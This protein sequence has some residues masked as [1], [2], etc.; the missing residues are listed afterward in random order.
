MMQSYIY[1]YVYMCIYIYIYIYMYI[2]GTR[3]VP[4]PFKVV[5]DS[6]KASTKMSANPKVY[7]TCVRISACVVKSPLSLS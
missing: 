1:I 5:R 3:C 4:M 6:S 2:Y 7:G